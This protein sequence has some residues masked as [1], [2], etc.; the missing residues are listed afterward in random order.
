MAFS[1]DGE[2]TAHP[3]FPEAL[4]VAGEVN[5][6][7]RI[8]SVPLVIMTNG[9][10]LHQPPVRKAIDQLRQSRGELWIKL[11]AGTPAYFQLIDRSRV[12]F[13]QIIA[14]IRDAGRKHPVVIQSMF[15][16]LNGN[17]PPASEFEAY[18]DRLAELVAAG[19]HIRLV[20]LYTVARQPAESYVSPLTERQ[21]RG[22]LD[23][24]HWRL[25]DLPCE[26]FGGSEDGAE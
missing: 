12:K 18:C 9:S 15:V 8:G 11:D 19:C 24:L 3:D 20:Q 2:P 5:S 10:L 7:M 22:L 6:Q 4:Q 23:Y 21:L 1:G 25:P 17:A 13:E 26:M 16:R 14:N